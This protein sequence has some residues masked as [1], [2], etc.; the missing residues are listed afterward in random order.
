MFYFPPPYVESFFLVKDEETGDAVIGTALFDEIAVAI[1]PATGEVFRD[2]DYIPRGIGND[3]IVRQDQIAPDQH[4]SL[5]IGNAL[6]RVIQTGASAFMPR[7]ADQ[8]IVDIGESSEISLEHVEFVIADYD[9][10]T[11]GILPKQVKDHRQIVDGNEC[12][13]FVARQSLHARTFAA[14]LHDYITYHDASPNRP[15]QQFS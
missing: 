4:E 10:L 14:R 11:P 12:F 8:F 9:E 2:A 5:A 3:A 1:T 13:R 15:N 7:R 6:E